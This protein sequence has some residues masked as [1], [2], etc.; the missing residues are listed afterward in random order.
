[1]FVKQIVNGLG[2]EFENSG[3]STRS[4]GASN[5]ITLCEPIVLLEFPDASVYSRVQK[6]SGSLHFV[7]GAPFIPRHHKLMDNGQALLPGDGEVLLRRRLGGRRI[8]AWSDG[9][10]SWVKD[11]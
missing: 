2:G 10:V 5:L 11:H 1:M 3:A 8:T 9:L 7:S 6:A 4:G